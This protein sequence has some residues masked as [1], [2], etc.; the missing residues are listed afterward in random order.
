[1]PLRIKRFQLANYKAVKVVDITPDG[2]VTLASKEN[3]EGKSSVLDGLEWLLRGPKAAPEVPVRTGTKKARGVGMICDAEGTPVLT[4]EREKLASGSDKLIVR[5][6][7]EDDP[8]SAPQSILDKLFSLVAFEP[9]KLERMLVDDPKKFADQLRLLVGVSTEDLDRKVAELTEQRKLVGRDRDGAQARADAAGRV[10]AEKPPVLFPDLPLQEVDVAE[11]AKELEAVRDVRAHN[12]EIRGGLNR[13]QE[14]RDR[15]YLAVA[16]MRDRIK[17][18]KSQLADARKELEVRE[19]SEATELELLEKVS[20][21]VARLTDPDDTAIRERLAS[22]S[23]V[24]RKVRHNAQVKAERA[25]REQAAAE[26]DTEA[27]KHAAKYDALTERIEKLRADKTA[28]IAAVKMP[29]P[30]LAFSEDGAVTL[31]DLPLA[32]AS[33]G[34]RYRT[35]AAMA[36]AQNPQL[37]ALILRDSKD[38]GPKSRAMLAE[39]AHEHGW[40]CWWETL[41]AST[42]GALVLEDGSIVQ[43]NPKAEAV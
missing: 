3:G 19:R 31:G 2:D 16:T 30:G 35:Y 14:A 17:E 12:T 1:M 25:S 8:A 42:P 38:L 26:L 11:L 10:L 6:A 33:E 21:T 43:V 32:Q 24:N 9:L 18:L 22:A 20:A 41:D 5:L 27:T 15:A 4:V 34:E 13:Q 7:G 39:V 40:Q 37:R 29:V 36:V 23:E 28:R